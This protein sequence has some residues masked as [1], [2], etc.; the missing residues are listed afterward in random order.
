M[1]SYDVCICYHPKDATTFDYCIL[2]IQ[3]NL[4]DVNHIYVIS[5]QRPENEDIVWI[6][7]SLFPFTKSDVSNYITSKGRVGWYYQQLLKLYMYTVLPSE[8]EYI[9]IVDSDLCFKEYVSFFK[10]NKIYLSV[11]PE[12]TVSY[13]THMEKVFPGLQKQ[14][15]FSGIVHHMMTKRS[16]MKEILAKL[17]EIHQKPAWQT[18]LEKV[19]IELHASSGMSEYEIYFNYCIKYHPDEYCIRILPFANCSNFYEFTTMQ[20]PIVALHTWLLSE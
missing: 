12:N 19:D 15:E 4:P 16:H 6:P 18:L 17:E 1:P 7:E 8:S 11:S 20:V 2:G 9:L 13:Y 14:T 5:A 10:E 3:Q